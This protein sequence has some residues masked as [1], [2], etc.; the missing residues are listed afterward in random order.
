MRCAGI[1]SIRFIGNNGKF[2][3]GSSKDLCRR[4]A[5]HLNFLSQ[6]KHCNKHLQNAFNK[7]GKESFIFEIIEKVN[8]INSSELL[9]LEKEYLDIFLK[10][11]SDIKYFK[12]YGYNLSQVTSGSNSVEYNP[13]KR[14]VLVFDLNMNFIEEISG[15]R[16]TERKYNVHK[17][18]RCCDGK[19]S[20]C[21]NY[22]F[23][24]SDNVNV[25]YKK[26]EE[27]RKYHKRKPKINKNELSR[28]SM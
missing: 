22:I 16:E 5:E 4:G 11:S 25:T 24:Y 12:K 28:K 10:A 26:K 15:V 6:G 19:T 27:W 3:I 14:K 13:K 7:Y 21:G 9:K 8:F 2:Y 23:R 18:K 20:R 1:Y 17:I